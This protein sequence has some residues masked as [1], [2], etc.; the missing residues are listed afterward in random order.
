MPCAAI[1]GPCMKPKRYIWVL[2]TDLCT[3]VEMGC[4]HVPKI[5]NE[6]LSDDHCYLLQ[7]VA[8]IR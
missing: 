5:I 6:T 7:Y 3:P 4:L 8:G 2:I 1:Q